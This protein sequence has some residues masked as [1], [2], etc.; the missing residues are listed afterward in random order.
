MHC[1]ILQNYQRSFKNEEPA[2]ESVDAKGTELVNVCKDELSQTSA[3]IK[4]SDLNE[5]WGDALTEL[6]SREEKLR[7]GLA[8]AENYQVSHHSIITP[9]PFPNS[10]LPSF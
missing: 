4:L 9:P 5:S 2:L 1:S 8:L 3:R 7:K 10:L 6:S